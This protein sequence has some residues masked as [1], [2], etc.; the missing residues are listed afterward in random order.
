MGSGFRRNEGV[1]FRGLVGVL[2]IQVPA[3]AGMTVGA[4]VPPAFAGDSE[5]RGYDGGEMEI[6]VPAFAG[7]T[8]GRAGMTGGR[9]WPAAFAGDSEGRGGDGRGRGNDG[10]VAGR[11]DDE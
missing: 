9:G 5:G 11:N 8:E 7:M 1:V 10:R 4:R 6:E 3:F 2:P